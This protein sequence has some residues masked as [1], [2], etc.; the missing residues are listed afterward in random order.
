MRIALGDLAF[1]A[2]SGSCYRGNEQGFSTMGSGL[3][4]LAIALTHLKSERAAVVA[5]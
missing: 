1:P 3:T 2:A 5:E 4:L